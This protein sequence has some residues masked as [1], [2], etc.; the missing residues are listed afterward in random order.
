MTSDGGTDA[1]SLAHQVNVF[2]SMMVLSPDCFSI[3]CV[4]RG[5]LNSSAERVGSQGWS[6][7]ENTETWD[8]EIDALEVA[9]KKRRLVSLTVMAMTWVRFQ[10]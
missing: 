10:P 8:L 1:P 7:R 9:S 6:G 5:A 4:G 3:R 2:P